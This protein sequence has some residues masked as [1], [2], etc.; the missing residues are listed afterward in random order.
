MSPH[1]LLKGS[2]SPQTFLMGKCKPPH[3][4][5]GKCGP[6]HF[7][8]GMFDISHFSKR[9]CENSLHLPANCLHLSADWLHPPADWLHSPADWLYWLAIGLHDPADITSPSAKQIFGIYPDFACQ[10][11]HRLIY[12]D[13]IINSNSFNKTTKQG[14]YFTVHSLWGIRNYISFF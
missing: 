12:S 10:Y 5:K 6:S 3:F 13:G 7:T 11:L 8:K 4:T 2:V 9:Q 14:V 1:T